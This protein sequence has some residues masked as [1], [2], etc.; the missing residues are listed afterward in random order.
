MKFQ[1]D[2]LPVEDRQRSAQR[3]RGGG[4][5]VEHRR[6][7]AFP[8][9][10]PP[11]TSLH[12]SRGSRKVRRVAPLYFQPSRYQPNRHSSYISTWPRWVI[13]RPVEQSRTSRKHLLAGRFILRCQVPFIPYFAEGQ[14]QGEVARVCAIKQQRTSSLRL[15]SNVTT[16]RH[17]GAWIVIQGSVES[18]VE[19]LFSLEEP[20]RGR[21]LALVKSWAT[22]NSQED[23]IPPQEQ[24]VSWLQEDF[25]LYRDVAALLHAW[26]RPA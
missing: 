23:W 1:R 24:V 13:S 12:R 6:F 14:N 25:I 21:F 15:L 7:N 4:C 20:W 5:R 17:R 2:S 3:S 10:G 8:P 9:G 22:G 11:A 18:L 16:R 19:E 26:H